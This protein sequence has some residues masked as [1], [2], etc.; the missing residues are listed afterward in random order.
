MIIIIMIACCYAGALGPQGMT[1]SITG[2]YMTINNSRE[3]RRACERQC[4]PALGPSKAPHRSLGWTLGTFL[5][6]LACFLWTLVNLSQRPL[7]ISTHMA[8]GKVNGPKV[9]KLLDR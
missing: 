6:N 4:C 8:A 1:L 9:A 2:G 5:R 3:T 7:P